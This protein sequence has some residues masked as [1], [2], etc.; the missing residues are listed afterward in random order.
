MKTLNL[1][2]LVFL[3]VALLTFLSSCKKDADTDL[4]DVPNI[5]GIWKVNSGDAIVYQNG[6]LLA[7]IKMTTFGTLTFEEDGIGYA[8]FGIEIAGESE[9]AKGSFNWVEDGFELLI[10]KSGSETERWA[11]VDDEKNLQ[12]VQYTI[13]DDDPDME[14]EL[15]LRLVRE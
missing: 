6:V 5:V 1:K 7:D 15:T 9:I 3:C 4:T 2:S 8:D 11:R 10:T 13:E 12:T 14:T